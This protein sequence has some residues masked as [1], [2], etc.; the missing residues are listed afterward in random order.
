MN[1][2][3]IIDL[4][5]VRCHRYRRAIDQACRARDEY[6]ATPA[7]FRQLCQDATDVFVARPIVLP[8]DRFFKKGT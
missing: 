5:Q 8:S 7:Q 2:A 3:M 1:E 6:G 4:D